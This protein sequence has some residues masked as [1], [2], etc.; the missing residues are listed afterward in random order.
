MLNVH[1]IQTKFH[2]H[3]TKI[4]ITIIHTYTRMWIYLCI[5]KQNSWNIY[6][7]NITFNIS[8]HVTCVKVM[9]EIRNKTKTIT[10]INQRTCIWKL[11]FHQKVL[12]L[13]RVIKVWFPSHAFYL[14]NLASFSS[15]FNVL[16]VDIRILTI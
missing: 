2:K 8:K 16:E 13:F 14:L 4:K 3:R 6:L 5:Y 9:G 11:G 7:L 15:S 12:C 10:D 1:L